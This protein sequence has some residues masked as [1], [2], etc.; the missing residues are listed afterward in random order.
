MH[1]AALMRTDD[2]DDGYSQTCNYYINF[3]LCHTLTCK[4]YLSPS[5]SG[6]G[7]VLPFAISEDELDNLGLVSSMMAELVMFGCFSDWR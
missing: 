2:D 7:L 5:T 3:V 6:R 1:I 4:P